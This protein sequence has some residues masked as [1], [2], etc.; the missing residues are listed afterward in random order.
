MATAYFI[1][2]LIAYF[3]FN[4]LLLCYTYDPSSM[5]SVNRAILYFPR[6]KRRVGSQH[7]GLTLFL[8]ELESLRRVGSR[9]HLASAF[10]KVARS[11][12]LRCIAICSRAT[13][14]KQTRGS[15]GSVGCRRLARYAIDLTALNQLTRLS[16]TGLTRHGAHMTRHGHS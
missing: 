15:Q 6:S 7:T 16:D 1:S 12:I 14:N 8:G 11:P 3:D 5:H 10:K 2:I 13:R 9:C 4:M